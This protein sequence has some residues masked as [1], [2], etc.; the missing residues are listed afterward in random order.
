MS[1]KVN[2][3]GIVPVS[4]IDWHG[5]S[6]CV[7]FF[8][9]CNFR[10]PY[11]QNHK[12]VDKVDRRDI[13]KVKKEIYQSIDFISAIVFSG[14]EPTMQV[15][16]LMELMEFSKE[17][18]LLVGIE[19]NGYY[20]CVLDELVKENLLDKIFLDVKTD[21]MDN[22]KYRIITG[23]IVD[24]NKNIMKSLM[25]KNVD[26]EVRTT[27]FRSTV[28]DVLPIAMYLKDNGYNRYTLQQGIPENAPD[29]KIRR[30]NRLTK[31][32]MEKIAQDVSSVGIDVKIVEG[33]YFC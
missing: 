9:G 30:E 12:I 20:S 2:F 1:L 27:V 6:A 15:Y 22:D 29:G 19:T 16:A 14:G 28:D 8:G 10:C 18:G 31:D 4:T 7:I 26:I 24:A 11:C 3:G 25:I 32:E 33:K 23:G 13:D 17:N 5:K 21:P